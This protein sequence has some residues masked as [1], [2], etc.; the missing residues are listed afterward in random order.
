MITIVIMRDSVVCSSLQIMTVF[1]ETQQIFSKTFFRTAVQS[2]R[3][4][5]ARSKIH[6]LGLE[7]F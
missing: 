6:V 3:R 4:V 5:E 7:L 1:K 2:V